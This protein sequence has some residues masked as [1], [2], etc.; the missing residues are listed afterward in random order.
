MY[1]IG[2]GVP[3]ALRRPLLVIRNVVR[4]LGFY[5]GR[6]SRT[7]MRYVR[8]CEA[9]PGLLGRKLEELDARV[10]G[11]SE[12][13]Y[14][15][16]PS[17]GS[18]EGMFQQVNALVHNHLLMAIIEGRVLVVDLQSE[19]NQYLADDKVGAEN[20]WE[21]FFEQPFNVGLK[22]IP[23]DAVVV[24][25][26][27]RTHWGV[28]KG[29]P[30]RDFGKQDATR[31][32]FLRLCAR[33]VRPN[34]TTARS[35]ADHRAALFDPSDKVLGIVI[36]ET[37]YALGFEHQAP[38]RRDIDYAA[39]IE[40]SMRT[41][42]CNRVFLATESRRVYE[43]LDARFP[44][45]VRTNPREFYDNYY[46][47]RE[48]GSAL[49]LADIRHDRE[50]DEYLRGLEYIT[51]VFLLAECDV[52]LGTP[53]GAFSAALFLNGGVFEDVSVWQ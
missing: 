16:M 30:S 20:A 38:G 10:A 7:Y 6:Q 45:I 28:W 26:H 32:D 39:Q 31:E 41:H 2:L 11:G 51:T 36:R 46:E 4:V 8:A 18:K 9:D 17:A 44:G 43:S 22:D 12:V 48:S 5:G 34:V 33:F 53:S 52:L 14:Y 49:V 25:G 29:D 3:I 24:R 21:H 1:R 19:K 15:I 23:G 40:R 37:D 13:G 27:F 42:G 35:I 47:G 50:N